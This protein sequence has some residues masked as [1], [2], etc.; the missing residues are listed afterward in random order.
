MPARITP[1][2]SEERTGR[3]I[4]KF[5]VRA[6]AA[7]KKIIGVHRGRSGSFLRK[8]SSAIAVNAKKIQTAKTK[9]E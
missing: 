8:R 5:A 9:S 3:T 7:I 6:T 1:N 4:Y 2:P